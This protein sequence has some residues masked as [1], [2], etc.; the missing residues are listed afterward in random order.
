M[1]NDNVDIKL[2]LACL[3]FIQLHALWK[4]WGEEGGS[5]GPVAPPLDFPKFVHFL[6][7]PAMTIVFPSKEP[8]LTF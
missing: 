5:W 6:M 7:L 8:W 4:S 2:T 3:L 1:K